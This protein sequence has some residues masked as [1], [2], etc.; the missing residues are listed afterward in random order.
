MPYISLNPSPPSPFPPS[1]A[2]PPS[3]SSPFP[4]AHQH[5]ETQQQL[6][7]IGA[8]VISTGPKPRKHGA[9]RKPRSSYF[10]HSPQMHLLSL[11]QIQTQPYS[12]LEAAQWLSSSPCLPTQS[13][14]LAL[15]LSPLLLA[16]RPGSHRFPTAAVAEP[17][18]RPVL[19]LPAHRMV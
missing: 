5:T 3:P 12:L 17:S 14:P 19:L 11:H 4:R 2:Q 9:V 7:A 18:N 8:T 1:A 10:K 13:A 6:L 15:L 16:H